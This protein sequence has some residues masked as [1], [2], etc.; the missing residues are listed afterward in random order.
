MLFCL[1]TNI[2]SPHQLPLARRLVALLGPEN[3]RYI[4]TEP[5]HAE[6]TSLGW[7]EGEQPSWL[8]QPASQPEQQNEAKEWIAH[9]DVV[10]CGSRDINLFAGRIRNN[11]LTLYMSE[12]WFKP[13]LG[14]LRLLHPRF[15]RMVMRFRQLARSPYLHYLPIGDYA[16]AD[17]RRIA[18]FYSPIP[19]LTHSRTNAFSYSRLHLW[20]YFIEPPASPPPCRQREGALHILWAG[21]MLKLKRLDTLIKAVGFLIEAGKDVRL[22]LVGHG[23]EESRLQ[24]MANRINTVHGSRFNGSAVQGNTKRQKQTA[25]P[26]TATRPNASQSMA[27]SLQPTAPITLH[28]PVP[29]AEVRTLMRQA[30]VY[31]LPSN[32]YEGWGAVVNEALSEGCAV[33]A[34][35][36]AGAA[37]TMIRNGENGLL[38]KPGDWRQLA[39]HLSCL[40]DDAI[41]RQRMAMDGQRTILEQWS[42]QIAAERLLKLCEALLAGQP[43]PEFHEGSLSS[44][45]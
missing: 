11:K 22:T 29:I 43:P 13:P 16:A 7:G 45:K 36:A 19:A 26:N 34:S 21:R 1:V 44:P 8:M 31:V 12:R 38:F 5:I 17:M 33:V 24:K 4:A 41:M 37:K 27:Y 40:H 10:L 20:G 42:P 3:F 32:G 14:M 30:D 9:A 39:A 15:L 18:D 28:S 6:R 23:P 35:E 2:V 25:N